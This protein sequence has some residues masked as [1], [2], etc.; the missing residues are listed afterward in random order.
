[1]TQIPQNSLESVRLLK[2]L[3]P[4]LQDA[5]QNKRV[6]RLWEHTYKL[7]GPLTWKEFHQLAG[8]GTDENSEPQPIPS[9]LV[10]FDKDAITVSPYALKFWVSKVLSYFSIAPDKVLVVFVVFFSAK[11]DDVFPQK[12]MLWVVLIS[13]FNRQNISTCLNVIFFLE[14]ASM[15]QLDAC[16]TGDQEVAVLTPAGSATFFHGD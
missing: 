11:I 8:R 10:G 14:L 3:Q 9:F 5:I 15:A 1:M 7:Q 12:H 6:T 13:S 2:S 4:L 16:Q